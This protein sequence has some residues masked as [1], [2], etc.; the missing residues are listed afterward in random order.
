MCWSATADL[1]AGAGVAAIGVASVAQVR[2]RRDLPLAALPLLLG[3][4][5]I[6][7]SAVW[8]A[9]GGS[10]PA[11]VAWAVIAM[12]LLAVWVPAG[13]WCA[14]PPSARRGPGFLLA[15]GV[16][17][18]AGLGYGI[19]TGPVTAEIRGHTVGYAVDLPFPPVLVVG[20]VLATV[21]SL[22]FSGDRRLLALGVLVAV[23]ASVCFALWRLEF[24]STWCAFA[25]LWSVLLLGWARGRRAAPRLSS[26]TV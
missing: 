2:G 22:L 11:T 24:V 17:T 26:R 10:G 3:A 20:Y 5:Q 7:E 15:V 14:A 12:P 1:V 8:E 13:V 6:V 18:A 23:G 21:G 4:H 19:A 25:A 9:G 16:A